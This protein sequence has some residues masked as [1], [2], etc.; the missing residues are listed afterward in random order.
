[1]LPYAIYIVL[2]GGGVVCVYVPCYKILHKMLWKS[3]SKRDIS[4]NFFLVFTVENLKIDLTKST[5]T[6]RSQV[7]APA[8]RTSRRTTRAVG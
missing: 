4:Q 8:S 2:P 6:P 1:M 7:Q 3:G 5:S